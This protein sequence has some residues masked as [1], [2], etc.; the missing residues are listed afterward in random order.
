MHLIGACLIEQMEVTVESVVILF[1][2][3]YAALSASSPK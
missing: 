2:P 3:Y 1:K